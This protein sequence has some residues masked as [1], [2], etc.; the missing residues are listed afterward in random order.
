M[1]KDVHEMRRR[2]G[3]TDPN[4]LAK[5]FDSP[6]AARRSYSYDYPG[7]KTAK[8]EH[9]KAQ[10]VAKKRIRNRW[11]HGRSRNLLAR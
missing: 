5:K 10:A 4:P 9:Y 8:W 3:T 11:Y 7:S 1:G 6:A 2:N